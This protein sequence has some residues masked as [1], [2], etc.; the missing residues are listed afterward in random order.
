MA[1][2]RTRRNLKLYRGGRLHATEAWV[3]THSP[4]LN[5]TEQAFLA[6]SARL[7]QGTARRRRTLVGG[8][9]LLTIA[10][11]LAAGLAFEQR[12]Q[13]RAATRRERSLRTQS[14]T[15]RLAAESKVAQR[16]DLTLSLLLA[17][18]PRRREDSVQ[19]RGALQPSLLSNPQVLGYMRSAGNYLGGFGISRDGYR[20]AA[21]RTDGRVDIWDTRTRRLVGAP[22]V[23][24]TTGVANVAISPDGRLVAA[25]DSSG[26]VQLWD[27]ASRRPLGGLV[28]LDGVIG[29]TAL[30]FD[31]SGRE[32][33][34]A[35]KGGRIDA[36]AV[37]PAATARR[38]VFARPGDSVA[39]FAFSRDGRLLAVATAAG[40]G[41]S[42]RM[43]IVE[44]AS[45]NVQRVIE[46]GVFGQRVG[47][48]SWSPN[49]RRV[50]LGM[51]G[52]QTNAGLFDP[53]AGVRIGDLW[54]VNSAVPLFTTKSGVLAVGSGA[55][56][57][58]F[59]RD[60]DTGAATDRSFRVTGLVGQ[61][62]GAPAGD[63]L[64]TKDSLGT[65]TIV[66]LG[67]SSKLAD[68]VPLT[69]GAPLSHPPG[70]INAV[71]YESPDES[72]AAYLGADGSYTLISLAT[73]EAL[74]RRLPPMGGPIGPYSTFGAWSP[75]GSQ[76]AVGGSNAA[77]A[78]YDTT[79]GRLLRTFPV[80]AAYVPVSESAKSLGAGAPRVVGQLLWSADGHWIAS[81]MWDRVFLF[82]AATGKLRHT[83]TGLS[84]IVSA[85]AFSSDSR[86]IAAAS[87]A[88]SAV[89]ADVAPGARVGAPIGGVG[90]L[91]WV[92][93]RLA[94]GNWRTGVTRIVDLATRRAIGPRVEAFTAGNIP[95]ASSPDGTILLVSDGNLDLQLVDIASGAPLGDPY[96]T[97][98]PSGG[99]SVRA[100]G[101]AYLGRLIDVPLVEWNID[102]ESWPTK[103]CEDAGRNLT[104]EEWARE[105]PGY[106]Y[107]ATCP[108]W[109]VGPASKPKG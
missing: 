71:V 101:K 6:A 47:Q 3:A 67:G 94:T 102:P 74:T 106:P 4:S 91:V 61:M 69:G 82:D 93:R 30:Q 73:G 65:I 45:G 46:T 49:G 80:P 38:T 11:L 41:R 8:F 12:S 44:S 21:G 18:A 98:G 92:G 48:I 52:A 87:F 13:A 50:A 15:R 35:V 1:R 63:R 9:A 24:A 57:E 70:G 10:A 60:S 40:A 89:L 95:I 77:I 29:F 37:A 90:W 16:T 26:T 68:A 17:A 43:A 88:N 7:E 108:Q 64:Y 84:E 103:A 20:I 66:D 96:P 53:V 59:V 72:R 58:L 23:V 56:N 39:S 28:T 33:F 32:L 25:G 109:S 78:I 14:D 105:L 22:L 34:V 27:V 54:D 19:T 99:I 81:A 104:R 107:R 83:V 55:G 62:V 75:D 76:F 51:S 36:F 86:R 31:P 100:D 85:V 97:L 79:S 42:T 2:G 5:E